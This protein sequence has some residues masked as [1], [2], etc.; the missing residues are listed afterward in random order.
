MSGLVQGIVGAGVCAVVFVAGVSVGIGQKPI[1]VVVPEKADITLKHEG[2]P[3]D[4]AACLEWV[5]QHFK[6]PMVGQF[7]MICAGAKL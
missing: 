1:T 3:S 7:A 2:I 5:A 4:R 6:D